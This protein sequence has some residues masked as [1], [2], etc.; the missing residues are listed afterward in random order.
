MFSGRRRRV[1]SERARAVFEHR[2]SESI[3]RQKNGQRITRCRETNGKGFSQT[4]PSAAMTCCQLQAAQNRAAAWVATRTKPPPC[5]SLPSFEHLLCLS[6]TSRRRRRRRRPEVVLPCARQTILILRPPQPSRD[7]CPPSRRGHR[8]HVRERKPWSKRLPVTLCTY[9]PRQPLELKQTLC[10]LAL[11]LPPCFEP[12]PGRPPYRQTTGRQWLAP[13]LPAPIWATITP[14]TAVSNLSLSKPYA[15]LKPPG[16]A[17]LCSCYHWYPVGEAC[18]NGPRSLA[19]RPPT[20]L[21]SL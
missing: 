6:P 10:H 12:S 2:V 11:V 1:A 20:L 4:C 14:T 21:H 9:K 13:L 18:K 19:V 5:P 15:L 8:A 16:R 7:L 3:Q 17:A